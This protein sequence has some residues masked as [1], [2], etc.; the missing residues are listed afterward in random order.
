MALP[1]EGARRRAAGGKRGFS[2]RGKRAGF[3]SSS[4]SPETGLSGLRSIRA[5]A[6]EGDPCQ[7]SFSP[8]VYSASKPPSFSAAMAIGSAF[9]RLRFAI[10]IQL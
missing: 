2:F 1:G 5:P 8:G 4:K 10:M 9:L 6:D 7:S 3:S